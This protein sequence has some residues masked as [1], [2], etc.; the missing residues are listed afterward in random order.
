MKKNEEQKI[1]ATFL[2][3]ETKGTDIA[4]NIKDG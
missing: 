1:T 4:N 2:V 3:W